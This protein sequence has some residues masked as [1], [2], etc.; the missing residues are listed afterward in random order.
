MK[1]MSSRKSLM[2]NQSIRSLH[3]EGLPLGW[4][5]RV[6]EDGRVYYV[7]HNAKETHWI[8][9]ASGINRDS[10]FRSSDIIKSTDDQMSELKK[11]EKV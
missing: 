8:L 2:R 10:Y 11:S 9:P 6:T 5:Q 4:E 7:D 3:T 1:D